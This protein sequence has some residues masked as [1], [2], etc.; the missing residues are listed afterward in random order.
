[1]TTETILNQLGVTLSEAKAFILNNVGQPRVIYDVA[2]QHSLTYDMLAEILN[3]ESIDANVVKS[4]FQ[5][6]GFDTSSEQPTLA[7]TPNDSLDLSLTTVLG[8]SEEAIT[9]D[10]WNQNITDYQQVLTDISWE[11]LADVLSSF[12][13]DGWAN[14]LQELANNFAPDSSWLYSF[15]D[16]YE[17][18]SGSDFDTTF[19]R[20]EWIWDDVDTVLSNSSS[21]TNESN[22][23]NSSSTVDLSSYEELLSIFG[24]NLDDVTSSSITNMFANNYNGGSLNDFFANMGWSQYIEQMSNL[25]STLYNE[26]LD[27]NSYMSFFDNLNFDIQGYLDAVYAMDWDAYLDGAISRLDIYDYYNQFY[28]TSANINQVEPTGVY[29]EAYVDFA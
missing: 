22:T 12:D 27:M 11:G 8:L 15:S 19:E 14:D 16:W 10:N 18:L 29:A 5:G 26:T 13:W 25:S 28:P 24:M 4:F 1:M 21:D 17:Q 6:Q 23:S 20:T 3:D 2:A 9:E 7:S